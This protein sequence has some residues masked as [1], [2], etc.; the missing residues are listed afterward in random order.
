MA[1]SEDESGGDGEAGEAGTG[2]DGQV[3]GR[4]GQAVFPGLSPGRTKKR[5]GGPGTD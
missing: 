4:A 2:T 1:E 3:A 5:T